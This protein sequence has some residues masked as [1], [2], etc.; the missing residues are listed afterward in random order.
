ME[1]N[2]D[3]K[4]NPET[5]SLDVYENGILLGSI[6]HLGIKTTI[7]YYTHSSSGS[8]RT[9]TLNENWAV[10]SSVK[11]ISGPCI[12]EKLTYNFIEPKTLN[13]TFSNNTGI[14]SGSYSNVFE[15]QGKLA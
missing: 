5:D 15:I 6:N 8:T 11:V 1:S 4:Y 10:I 14:T 13:Y 2:N 7:K 3:I 9:L 12:G